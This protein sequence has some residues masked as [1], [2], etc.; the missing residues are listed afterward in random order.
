MIPWASSPISAL[1]SSA[2]ETKAEGAGV[3]LLVRA[4]LARQ[5]EEAGQP[6]L[7]VRGMP[8]GLPALDP[9]DIRLVETWVA[10]GARP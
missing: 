2:S 3:A 1:A 9:E 5:D 4:L 8:L 6:V 7:D 10:Q